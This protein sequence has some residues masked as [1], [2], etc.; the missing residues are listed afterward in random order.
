[1]CA[2]SYKHQK[3]TKIQNSHWKR[4]RNCA[5]YGPFSRKSPPPKYALWVSLDP[6]PSK[7]NR[8]EGTKKNISWVASDCF[9]NC[10]CDLYNYILTLNIMGLKFRLNSRK[11]ETYV[12]LFFKQKHIF[13]QICISFVFQFPFQC[14]FSIRPRRQNIAEL[15]LNSTQLNLNSTQPSLKLLSLA[16]L[17]S[18]L[19]LWWFFQQ[20][21]LY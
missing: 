5:L 6:T 4:F 15:R 14:L 19:F 18:S 1:M 13:F 2:S 11:N 12:F 21:L 3:K 20:L 10:Y 16:L 7:N 8:L 17:S 9:T